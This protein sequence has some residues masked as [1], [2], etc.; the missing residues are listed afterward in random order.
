M[1]FMLKQSIP[2]IAYLIDF[3]EHLTVRYNQSTKSL[4]VAW[5]LMNIITVIHWGMHN[6]A[7]LP[8]FYLYRIEYKI[9]QSNDSNMRL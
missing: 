9:A 2:L 1:A 4:I 6:G 3:A 7:V 8:T 5:F